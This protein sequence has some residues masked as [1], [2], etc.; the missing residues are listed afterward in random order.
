MRRFEKDFCPECN[1]AS[2]CEEDC[3]CSDCLDSHEGDCMCEGCI[4]RRV[5]HAEGERECF[6]Y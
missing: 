1:G 3:E 2:E 4:E 6:D 5:E